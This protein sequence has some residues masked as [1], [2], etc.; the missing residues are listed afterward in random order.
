[1]LGTAGLTAGMSVSVL[2]HCF[3]P[4]RGDVLVT[5]ASGGVGSLAVTIL[6]KLGYS[7]AA[8]SG[9][10]GAASFLTG[11]G[12]KK[13]L[14]RTEATDMSGKP[15]LK[16][17]WAGVI[18]TVGGDIL[19]TAI[20]STQPKGVVTCC[21]NVASPELNLTV[22]PFILRGVSLVGIDSQNLSMDRRMGI[23]QRLATEWKPPRLEELC[24]EVALAELNE[25]I[26]L[27]LKG[28]QTGRIVVNL[29]T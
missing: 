28:G 17:L 11:L 14:T 9:K 21:G 3:G 20:K 16:P 4:D 12:A 13:I 22:F 23:W 5:G 7:V 10:E 1:M 27:I 29:G 8:V 26:D 6:A 15:L 18:D 25:Q 2:S 24:R 19:T